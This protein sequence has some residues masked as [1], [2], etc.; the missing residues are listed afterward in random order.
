MPQFIVR[1]IFDHFFQ[2]IK[3]QNELFK[4]RKRLLILRLNRYDGFFGR[5]LSGAT[6]ELIRPSR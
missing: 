6:F 5:G 4:P 2:I 1:I 3:G